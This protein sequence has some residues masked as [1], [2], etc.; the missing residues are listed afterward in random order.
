MGRLQGRQEGYRAG[1]RE[2]GLEAPSSLALHSCP[3]QSWVNGLH[4]V[5]S[6]PGEASLLSG[7]GMEL[8]GRVPALG[9]LLSP[10]HPNAWPSS[11]SMTPSQPV[12]S[13]APTRR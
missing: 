3:G 7:S 11:V 9:T 13:S 6:P 4:F 2:R 12:I 8:R 1:E 10:S 5:P